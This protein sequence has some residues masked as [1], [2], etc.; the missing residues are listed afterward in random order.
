MVQALR[1]QP[2]PS[3]LGEL[4]TRRMDYAGALRNLGKSIT[5]AVT[6]PGDAY[7]GK[8]DP[9]SPEGIARANTLAGLMAGSPGTPAGALGSGAGRGFRMLED[10]AQ[11]A[12]QPGIVAKLPPSLS[13]ADRT[14]Q[15]YGSK[16]K[17]DDV[18]H[19]EATWGMAQRLAERN[20]EDK[21]THG[22]PPMT[23]PEAF[24]HS[25]NMLW[26]RMG[27]PQRISPAEAREFMATERQAY[28]NPA[29]FDLPTILNPVSRQGQ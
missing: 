12:A 6:A 1:G 23:H 10:A 28:D 2:R 25:A 21:L 7:A 20:P 24:S 14:W 16:M 15:N 4:A 13:L 27:V 8:L 26:Q 11:S 19:H 22:Y 9:L 5:G 3:L 29:S 17:P 18:L